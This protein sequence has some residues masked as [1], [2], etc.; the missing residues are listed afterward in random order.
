MKFLKQ[1]TKIHSFSNFCYFAG[2]IFVFCANCHP[3]MS[4]HS[5]GIDAKSGESTAKNTSIVVGA[6]R[7]SAYLP[8]LKGKKVA[9]VVNQTSMVQN[10]Y[11]VDT[12]LKQGIKVGVIFAPEHGFRGKADAGEKV[13]NTID[14]QTGLPIISIYGKKNKP[15]SSD[16]K[17]IDV[18]LFDIQDVGVRFYTYISTLQYIM[19]AGAEQKI[20]VIVLDRP[21][22]NGHYVDGAILDKSLKSFVGMQAI[23]TVY[24]MTI[25]EYA[26][27][28]NE[29]GWLNQQLKCKLT[30]IPCLNYNHNTVYDLP[31]K[32]SPN[33][34]NLRSIYLYPSICYLEGTDVSLGRGTNKP[35]QMYGAPNFPKTDFAFTPGPNE[36]AKEPPHKGEICNGY[37]LS[38]LNLDKLHDERQIN[39]S[40]LVT[41]YK[42]FPDK[43]AFFLKGN[44]FDKLSGTTEL[45]TQ[46]IEGK[47]ADAI[48]A[49]WQDG[50]KRFKI[51][52]K[53][54]LLYPDFE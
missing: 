48:R 52:R 29:E 49:T 21:N 18:L 34:P 53:K 16:L 12:L 50:L 22:P 1:R 45:R 25:G 37:D 19:E 24:G 46:L 7:F 11:L 32:P 9:L 20:P 30:V 26:K 8:L 2:M 51:I 17:N 54:Y 38:N 10:K 3:K 44:F 23:P 28:L 33:L 40:Y 5:E 14:A 41:A 47:S 4:T 15:D 6:E 42:N 31:V 43:K 35:F 27:M 39:L 36:G 13:N